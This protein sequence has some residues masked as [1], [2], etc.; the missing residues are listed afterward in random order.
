MFKLQIGKTI[1]VTELV[2]YN[3]LLGITIDEINALT[4]RLEQLEEREALQPPPKPS[5]T[6]GLGCGCSVNAP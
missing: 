5:I 4:K 3:K 6:H 2:D 1:V